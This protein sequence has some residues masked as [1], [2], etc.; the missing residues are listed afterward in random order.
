M[1][2]VLH[3]YHYVN[4]LF[5]YSCHNIIIKQLIIR[6]YYVHVDGKAYFLSDQVQP[7]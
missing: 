7:I 4:H 3:N 5:L 2:E 6:V 1:F